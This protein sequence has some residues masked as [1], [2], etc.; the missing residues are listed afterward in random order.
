MI[1]WLLPL[2]I[3]GAAL[4]PKKRKN[5]K[6]IIKQVFERTGTNIN[7]CFPKLVKIVKDE[8]MT[9]YIYS[10]PIGLTSESIKKIELAISE[11]LWKIIEWEYDRYLKITVYELQLPDKWRIGEL[12]SQKWEIPIGKNHQ[13]ILYHDFDKYPHLLAG[14]TTRFGKTVFLKLLFGSLLLNQKCHVNF[15]I[16]DLKG[17]L[18]FWEY[19][20][21]P[22]VKNVASDL[23]SAC[24]ALNK[25]SK[26]MEMRQQQFRENRIK[27]IVDS[28]IKERTFIIV[29]E[30]A[31]LSPKLVSKD[32]KKYAEYCTNALG[33]IAR[34]GGAL[35]YRLI[36]ATQYP[37]REAVPGQVKMNIVARLAF[38]MPEMMGSKVILDEVGAEDL[39]SIPGRAIYK[40]ETK[41]EVQVPFISDKDL[42]VI[43]SECG[44]QGNFI[45]DNR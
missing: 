22:E 34:I 12:Q 5:D 33:K 4:V 31:E 15:Y 11:A 16:F 38:K 41:K 10:M 24:I 23:E 13:G 8:D 37:T 36:Y 26:E 2:S 7:E 6:Q 19:K 44:T 35:G 14:G 42:E 45:T 30:A 25:I 32:S 29:D 43:L 9:T 28:P 40:V 3:A 18:E 39:K 17:G 27:N 20:D 21:L 1:E